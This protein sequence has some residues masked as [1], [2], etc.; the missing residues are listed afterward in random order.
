MTPIRPSPRPCCINASS[1]FPR[2]AIRGSRRQEEPLNTGTKERLFDQAVSP[3][4]GKSVGS[5]AW[6]PDLHCGAVSG[7]DPGPCGYD[8]ARAPR[9]RFVRAIFPTLY[10]LRDLDDSSEPR[11]RSCRQ[12]LPPVNLPVTG[13]VTKATLQLYARSSSTGFGGA[14]RARPLGRAQDQL[15]QCSGGRPNWGHD[16]PVT[17]GNWISIDVTPLVTTG[18]VNLALTTPSSAAISVGS[19]EFTQKPSSR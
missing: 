14:L 7:P 15:L 13:R 2:S 9:R 16:G 1:R 19:R 17:S 6:G 18:L 11:V 12:K 3:S 10:E 4:R 8:V 5:R